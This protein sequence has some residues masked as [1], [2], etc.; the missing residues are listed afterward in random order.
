MCKK[1]KTSLLLRG[2]RLAVCSSCF[3]LLDEQINPTQDRFY[4]YPIMMKYFQHFPINSLWSISRE[5]FVKSSFR[6]PAPTI[7]QRKKHSSSTITSIPLS[8]NMKPN[9]T[10]LSDHEYHDLYAVIRVDTHGNRFIVQENLTSIQSSTLVA[11]FDKLTHH[12]GYYRV[13]QSQ[14]KEEL[15]R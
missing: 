4:K 12:Q 7:M 15:R 11:D 14:V 8:S 6:Y 2:A 10:N 3:S 13:K 9:A 1:I 5:D